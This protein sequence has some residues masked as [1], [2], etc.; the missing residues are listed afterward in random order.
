MKVS[1]QMQFCVRHKLELVFVKDYFFILI[2]KILIKFIVPS[3]N[4]VYKITIFYKFNKIFFSKK[5]I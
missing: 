5:F 3:I 2:T 4:I 1:T